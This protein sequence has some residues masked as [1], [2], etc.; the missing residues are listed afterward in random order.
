MSRLFLWLQRGLALAVA[1][2]TGV[3]FEVADVPLA[4]ILGPLIATALFSVSGRPVLATTRMRRLGQLV[5][6]AALG[7]NITGALLA[8]IVLWVPVMVVIALTAACVTGFFSVF[9]AHFG[10]LDRNTAF[11]AMMPGGLSEMANI[12]AAAGARSEPIAVAQTVRLG[13][14]VLVLPPTIIALDIHGTFATIVTAPSVPLPFLLP[15]FLAA[16]LGVMAMRWLGAANPWMLGALV[17]AAALSSFDMIGGHLPHGLF[18]GGQYLLGVAVGAR[19]RRDI[20]LRMPRL[21]LLG[22]VFTLLVTAALFGV[23]AILSAATGLDLATA[24]LA[25]SAG[26]IAEMSVTAQVLHLNSA[27]ILGFHVTR[28]IM[29]NAFAK[30]I[31][32]LQVRLRFLPAVERLEVAVFGPRRED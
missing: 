32:D 26:G 24:A 7:L 29:V 8:Q 23:A 12:G 6:G 14:V 3:A 21:F 20:V 17:A 27:L 25:S 18:I 19:F 1:A 10:R 13:L 15:L 31:L 22:V 28:A 2:A 5:I 11:F 30:T 9:Y 4:W 16:L